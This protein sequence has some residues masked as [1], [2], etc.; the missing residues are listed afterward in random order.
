MILTSV[1]IIFLYPPQLVDFLGREGT[2]HATYVQNGR[3]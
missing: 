3:Q 1:G 2:P